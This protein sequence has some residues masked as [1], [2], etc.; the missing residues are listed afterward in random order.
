MKIRSITAFLFVLIFSVT[1]IACHAEEKATVF[2][3]AP[4]GSVI[5]GATIQEVNKKLEVRENRLRR[6]LGLPSIA[7]EAAATKYLE[8]KEGSLEKFSG[9]QCMFVAHA[10]EPS[11]L[12]PEFKVWMGD[13]WDAGYFPVLERANGYI[14]TVMREERQDH[15]L[16]FKIIYFREGHLTADWKQTIWA[17]AYGNYDVPDEVPELCVLPAEAKEQKGDKMSPG[18]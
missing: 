16:H 13:N 7:E 11:F 1:A 10:N 5:A 2:L 12:D 18:K 3:I 9:T 6:Q 8:G 14:K 15:S 4:D 17:R